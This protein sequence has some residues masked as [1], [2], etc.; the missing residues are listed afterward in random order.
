M[1]R[2]LAVLAGLTLAV[3]VAGA[4]QASQTPAFSKPAPAVSLLG[5]HH[6]PLIPANRPKVQPR[7]VCPSAC[8]FYAGYYQTPSPA[9]TDALLSLDV[10]NPGR[11]GDFHTLGEITAQSLNQ[12][13]TV[14][15]G[16]NV[17]NGLYG[18]NLTHLFVSSFK[19]GS[20]QG[21]N[22]SNPAFTVCTTALCGAAPIVAPG[23]ALTS[24]VG[25]ATPPV[26]SISY[27]GS[28]YWVKFAG[29]W[30]GFFA[31]SNWSGVSPAFTNIPLFQGFGEVAAANTVPC[32]K[33]GSGTKGS[34][35][36][37]AARMGNLTY[38]GTTATASF[39]GNIVTNA[40]YYDTA[41]L[42]GTTTR[43]FAYGGDNTGC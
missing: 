18:D 33:M 21:Y 41:F 20:F 35:I 29:S 2:I 24:Y 42:S 4:A 13:Q 17:D 30:I 1:K 9:P 28:A 25:A 6:V 43:S 15:I 27:F 26:F 12:Q 14:E 23:G 8:Y 37:G 5:G 34:V 32:A 36:T 22:G 38:A 40:T 3:G 11:D 16:W 39:T 10:K 31:G 7:T 19:N